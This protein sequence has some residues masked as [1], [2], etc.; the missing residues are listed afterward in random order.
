M[1]LALKPTPLSACPWVRHPYAGPGVVLAVPKPLP[2][3][4]APWLRER[5]WRLK[6]YA[7]DRGQAAVWL[8]GGNPNELLSWLPHPPTAGSNTPGNLLPW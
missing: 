6:G 7:E 5:R 8:V 4:L 1:Q 2:L 3:G